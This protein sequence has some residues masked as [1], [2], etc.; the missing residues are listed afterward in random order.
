MEKRNSKKKSTPGTII[1]FTVALAVIAPEIFI[2]LLPLA[3]LV[4]AIA[5]ALYLKKKI[6]GDGTPRPMSPPPLR[7]RPSPP[8]DCPKPI[9]F[10]KDKGEHHVK[11]GKEIDPWD[12]PDIDIRKYQRRE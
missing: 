2:V 3:I 7:E 1:G 12:R 10:H 8:D 11:R 9:C 4:G 5:L 6:P